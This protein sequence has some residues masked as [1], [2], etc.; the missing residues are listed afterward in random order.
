M[1]SANMH[2]TPKCLIPANANKTVQKSCS[3]QLASTAHNRGA[4]RWTALSS[5]PGRG[6]NPHDPKV[7]GV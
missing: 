5:C 3:R 2:S 7:T 4:L 1:L 6:S